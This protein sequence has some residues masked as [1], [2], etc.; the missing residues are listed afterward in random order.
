MTVEIEASTARARVPARPPSAV[1]AP[2][3]AA[4]QAAREALHARRLRRP[5]QGLPHAH[6]SS[7]RRISPRRTAWP[8]RQRPCLHTLAVVRFE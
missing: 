7:R 6:R 2:P 8:L 4:L 3:A 1:L 5:S